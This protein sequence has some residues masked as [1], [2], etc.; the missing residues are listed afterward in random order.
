M[1]SRFICTQAQ[2]ETSSV[3]ACAWY[4][5][6]ARACSIIMGAQKETSS[7]TYRVEKKE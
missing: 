4:G 6:Q 5:E 1:S 3:A 7:K 2:K